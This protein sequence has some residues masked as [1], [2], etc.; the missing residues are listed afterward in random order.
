[1]DD[2]AP[3]RTLLSSNL[4]VSGYAVR[5]GSD[6]CEALK[7]IGEHPFDLLLLDVSLPGPNGLQMLEALRHTVEA[8]V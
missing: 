4:K 2:E 8:P 5:A 7:L 3:L 6:G 1:M